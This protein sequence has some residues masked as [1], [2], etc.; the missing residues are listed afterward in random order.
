MERGCSLASPLCTTPVCNGYSTMDHASSIPIPQD[1]EPDQEVMLKN[2]QGGELGLVTSIFHF[3]SQIE[4]IP[5]AERCLESRACCG[6]GDKEEARQRRCLSF[7]LSSLVG[8]SPPRSVLVYST[9]SWVSIAVVV[10][11]RRV[12]SA[13]CCSSVD[14]MRVDRLIVVI[15]SRCLLYV[16]VGGLSFLRIHS[17]LHLPTLARWAGAA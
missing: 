7:R 17:L 5:S 16:R 11:P 10:Q 3:P 4:A 2:L 6:A 1:L 12:Q 15:D 8:V 14:M 9:S 13:W